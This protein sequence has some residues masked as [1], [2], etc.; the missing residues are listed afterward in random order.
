[1]TKLEAIEVLLECDPTTI[2][3]EIWW[4]YFIENPSYYDA[5]MI[6]TEMKSYKAILNKYEGY[7]IREFLC[8]VLNL[9]YQIG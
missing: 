4:E 1:M 3:D 5:M 8:D 9:N 2:I 6:L 7:Y